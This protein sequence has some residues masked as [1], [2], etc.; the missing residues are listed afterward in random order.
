MSFKE[1]IE[2]DVEALC[3]QIKQGLSFS[4]GFGLGFV[5]NI[6]KINKKLSEVLSE[7]ES[8][9]GAEKIIAFEKLF[10]GFNAIRAGLE[11]L[12]QEHL[13][14]ISGVIYRS[15]S[16]A[17]NKNKLEKLF[18]G[19][20]ISKKKILRLIENYESDFKASQAKVSPVP[21]S[22][23]SKKASAS[24]TLPIEGAIREAVDTEGKLE[25]F[26][27]GLG[28]CGDGSGREGRDFGDDGNELST[29]VADEVQ[30]QEGHNIPDSQKK[31]IVDAIDSV[32]K[33][34]FSTTRE[35]FVGVCNAVSLACDKLGLKKA[36]SWFKDL[37]EAV[38]R[39]MSV[40]A[41]RAARGAGQEAVQGA[42]ATPTRV[43]P[44]RSLVQH[45][46]SV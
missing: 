37:S 39:G 23:D 12:K 43:K 34:N 8:K 19:E 35:F 16:I 28:V 20:K 11:G 10:D 18:D 6:L 9:S 17:V 38:K 3:D 44:D 21:A 4:N 22:H 15:F 26:I 27:D 31:V 46:R 36:A 25:Q 30:T 7:I 41:I 32:K 2:K 14:K 1:D 24:T 5:N 45:G 40:K 13:N 33:N 42:S 29:L